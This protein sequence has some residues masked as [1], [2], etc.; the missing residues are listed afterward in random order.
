MNRHQLTLCWGS[1]ECSMLTCTDQL[2]SV[3]S[4]TTSTDQLF[5]WYLL[6]YD[7]YWTD[8]LNRYSHYLVTTS[9]SVSSSPPI[10]TP[11]D[12]HDRF[13]KFLPATNSQLLKDSPFRDPSRNKYAI[14]LV[15]QA[16]KS[17]SE[18]WRPQDIPSVFFILFPRNGFH[19][20]R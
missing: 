15:N 3:C 11:S 18:I 19:R 9:S 20:R 14:G 13:R 5:A 4:S 2:S 17:L 10:S 8:I 6:V 7:E 1:Q 12:D 16:V